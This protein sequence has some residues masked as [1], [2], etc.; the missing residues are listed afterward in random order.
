YVLSEAQLAIAKAVHP[1]LHAQRPQPI[2]PRGTDDAT[3]DC[4]QICFYKLKNSKVY[5]STV[6]YSSNVLATL[7]AVLGTSVTLATLVWQLAGLENCQALTNLMLTGFHIGF[8]LLFLASAMQTHTTNS[9]C[10]KI[11][12]IMGIG[13]GAHFTV[14]GLVLANNTDLSILSPGVHVCLVDIAQPQNWLGKLPL[15]TSVAHIFLCFFSSI[16]YI[17]AAFRLCTRSRF[18]APREIIAVFMVYRGLGTLFANVL[19]GLLASTIVAFLAAFSSFHFS[20][21]MLLWA[22]MSR[23]MAAALWHR[24]VTDVC[25]PSNAFWMSSTYLALCNKQVMLPHGNA[26][27]GP[28]AR[29]GTWPQTPA[30]KP[31]LAQ[32]IFE[33]VRPSSPPSTASKVHMS[34]S[35]LDSLLAL[36][37]SED[38]VAATL[39][40]RGISRHDT[41]VE[42]S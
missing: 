29:G 33:I 11:F 21:W 18:I 2:E 14:F 23:I 41:I 22:A 39:P 20:C 32:V 16:S 27:S 13:L 31:S 9:M 8:A 28:G 38:Y 5:Q 4:S 19:F 3:N 12:F 30:A 6:P 37:N 10:I 34:N 35:S 7:Q 26:L 42:D 25:A 36:T 17:N 1:H 24:T 40:A 15:Y